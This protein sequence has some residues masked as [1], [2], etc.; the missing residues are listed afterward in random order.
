M[1]QNVVHERTQ[2]LTL[3]L[4]AREQQPRVTVANARSGSRPQTP[5]SDERG[6][7]VAVCTSVPARSEHVR[8]GGSAVAVV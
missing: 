2:A 3:M 8:G 1:I 7:P 6:V 5:R 4:P